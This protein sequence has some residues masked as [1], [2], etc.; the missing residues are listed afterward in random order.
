M[1]AVI[2]CQKEKL[3]E[4]NSYSTYDLVWDNTQW[5]S[6]QISPATSSDEFDQ[7]WND[8][9]EGAVKAKLYTL[10]LAV[11]GLVTNPEFSKAV[12]ASTK[13]N[14]F[15]IASLE[16]VFKEYPSF[17]KEVN[18]NLITNRDMHE[19]G[20]P[21][22]IQVSSFDDLAKK[23]NYI[24]KDTTYPYIPAIHVVNGDN[25]S[26]DLPPI[27]CPNIYVNANK[28]PELD[29]YVYAWKLESD[30][31]FK[32]ILINEEQSLHL[33]NPIFA[34]DNAEI[35]M[36][37]RK[38]ESTILGM[39]PLKGLNT[40]TQFHSC[41]YR[42]NYAYES[43]GYSELCMTGAIITGQNQAYFY[44]RESSG[45]SIEE[46]VNLSNCPHDEIGTDKQHWHFV[47]DQW[48][49]YYSVYAYWNCFERDWL[50]GSKNLGTATQYGTPIYLYGKMGNSGDWYAFNPSYTLSTVINYQ[51][52]YSNWV[53][54]YDFNSSKGYLKIWRVEL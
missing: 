21:L 22:N 6:L 46:W 27:V 48:T 26:M 40:T 23:L 18:S 32:E 37:H 42:L 33:K 10:G 28:F 52:I 14:D 41:E 13:S 43:S 7:F 47:S 38:R 36:I 24:D 3:P 8:A 16:M 1:F 31:S 54:H 51:T 11:R 4:S 17:L 5:K 15:N 34:I 53:E 20:H 9:S 49:P 39:K 44:L 45:S 35:G 2:S 25:L 19:A 12:I 50:S 29:E 30:G